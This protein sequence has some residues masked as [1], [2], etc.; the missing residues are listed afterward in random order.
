MGLI[1]SYMG[2]GVYGTDVAG[3]ATGLQASF[4]DILAAEVITNFEVNNKLEGKYMYK[5]I[6]GANTV[7]FP[8]AS[9]GTVEF[10][11][12]GDKATMRKTTHGTRKIGLDDYLV[13]NVTIYDADVAAEGYD[14]A[15]ADVKNVG[16]AMAQSH[17]QRLIVNLLAAARGKDNVGDTGVSAGNSDITAELIAGYSAITTFSAKG[18]SM[19]NALSGMKIKFD[20]LR[21][22]EKGRYFICPSQVYTSIVNNLTNINSLYAGAGSIAEGNVVKLMGFEL[23][24]SAEFGVNQ[25]DVNGDYMQTEKFG[26]AGTNLTLGICFT[27]EAIAH[28]SLI[29]VQIEDE[30]DASSA[31]TTKYIR[32]LVGYGILRNDRA[33]EV[34]ES[35]V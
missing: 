34:K 1:T 29:D 23:I 35:I 6:K 2:N 25:V 18:I 19:T 11:K 4:N 33:G 24:N 9:N 7:S 22:P 26:V 28:V 31:S 5:T 15:T 14:H 13:G 10:V 30:R 21:V 32:K 3:G 8:T 20:N 17:E 12:V 27:A 16:V